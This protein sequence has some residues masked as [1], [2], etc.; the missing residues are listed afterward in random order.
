MYRR[1][2]KHNEDRAVLVLDADPLEAPPKRHV[3][4]IVLAD[5]RR[6]L[7]RHIA[8]MAHLIADAAKDL[9]GVRIMCI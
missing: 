2:V 8:D 6:H 4:G 1:A 3:P 7:G 5:L 9:D